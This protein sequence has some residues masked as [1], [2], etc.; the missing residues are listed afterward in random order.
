MGYGIQG[1]K[2]ILILVVLRVTLKKK[3]KK[4]QAMLN[5]LLIKKKKK[6]IQAMLNKLLIKKKYHTKLFVEL[7]I[8]HY[9]NTK[10]LYHPKN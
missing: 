2:I 9:I 10:K 8:S 3:K 5:K 7:L 4:I 1:R 6:K